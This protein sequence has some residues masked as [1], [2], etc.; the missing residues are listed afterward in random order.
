MSEIALLIV[1]I[2]VGAA[3]YNSGYWH[4]RIYEMFIREKQHGTL[5]SD[6]SWGDFL[7]NKWDED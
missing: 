5:P 3:L 6:L 7:S 1:I 2:L 4:G